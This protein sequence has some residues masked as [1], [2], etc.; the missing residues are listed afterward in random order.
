MAAAP[1]AAPALAPGTHVSL[2]L[3][4]IGSLPARVDS[5]EPGAIHVVLAVKDTR[6]ARLAGADAALEAKTSRGIQ[7][8]AGTLELPDGIEVVRVLLH[9]EAER[10]QR[11]EWARIAA[12]VP[13]SVRAVDEDL[14]GDTH[15]LNVSAGGIL[16]TD[17]WKLPLGLDVRVEL[18]VDPAV[19]RLQAL[20]RVVR[21]P[22]PDQ[23]GVRIVNMARDHEERLVRFVRERERAALRMGERER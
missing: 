2:H 13:V 16:I 8:F 20:G 15:T 10:I 12:V 18:E 23:K 9:G 5:C 6:V 17:L 21:A 7:R 22:S 1:V 19:P 11:R 14:G 3:P 4:H